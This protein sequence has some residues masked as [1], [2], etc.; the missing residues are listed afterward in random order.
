MVQQY[1]VSAACIQ[2]VEARS[3][4]PHVESN[5]A[6]RHVP[7]CAVSIVSGDA[8]TD[9]LQPEDLKQSLRYAARQSGL[10]WDTVPV[11]SECGPV[12][13]MMFTTQES[14][15]YQGFGYFVI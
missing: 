1:V 6:P 13:E 11:R 3:F 7:R 10:D 4:M 12:V 9:T 2:Y 14:G 8:M 15:R 5:V